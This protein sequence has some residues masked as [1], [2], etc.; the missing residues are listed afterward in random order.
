MTWICG[1]DVGT[2]ST[3]AV[4]IKDGKPYHF[5]QIPSGHDYKKTAARVLEEVAAKGTLQQNDVSKIYTTGCGAAQVTDTDGR[6]GDLACCA[7]GTHYLLPDVRTVIEVGDRASKVLRVDENG[8]AIKFVMSERCASGCGRF[9]TIIAKV[10]QLNIREVGALSMMAQNPIPFATG[11]AVFGES[12]AVSRVAQ[13]TSKEDIL[14][15]VHMALATKIATM[16]ERVGLEGPCAMVGG[17]ALD[18]GLVK[19]VENIIEERLQVPDLPQFAVA[20]G[21]ALNTEMVPD[22]CQ[23]PQQENSDRSAGS[24]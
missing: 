7:K 8:K 9:L 20:V 4:L 1:I 3:K 5:H 11:C 23:Y 12:E 2:A 24:L 17:G 16:V 15:G 10:L 19:Q 6:V 21:A 22:S 13:G 14:A 18:K